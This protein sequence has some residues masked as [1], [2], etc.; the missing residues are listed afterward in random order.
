MKI[1]L[2]SRLFSELSRVPVLPDEQTKAN[3]DALDSERKHIENEGYKQ[4]TEERKLYANLIFNFTCAW[5]IFVGCIIVLCGLNKLHLSD[6][7]LTTLLGTTL[8]NSYGFF[9]IVTQYLFD[10]GKKKK[11]K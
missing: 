11:E 6:I 10:K 4:D 2:D 8:V 9:R 5:S 1:G 7:I 3:E